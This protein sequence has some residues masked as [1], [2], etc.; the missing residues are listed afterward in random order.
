MAFATLLAIGSCGMSTAAPAGDPFFLFATSRFGSDRE[1]DAVVDVLQLYAG[2]SD[3]ISLGLAREN[4]SLARRI[5][6]A[7]VFVLPPSASAVARASGECRGAGTIVYDPEHWNDT[8]RHEQDDIVGAVRN[9]RAAAA[10]GCAFALAP[11]GQFAGIV[12]GECFFDLD[13]ALHRKI[14]WSGVTLYDVQAQRLLS[15]S[16][17]SRGGFDAYVSFVSTVANEIRAAA[18]GVKVT[19][20]LS[21]RD[22]PPARMTAAIRRLRNVVDGFYLAY[23]VT[24]GT[25]C[26]YC[27]ETNLDEVLRCIKAAP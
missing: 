7:H 15:E 19:A 11:D 2:P 10:P 21:F 5:S 8:P 13:S 20:Q 22:T 24:A 14:D 16:C 4:P 1:R 6:P 3:Y 27:N 9:A 23:P 12:P 17:A 18:P 25:P 26:R